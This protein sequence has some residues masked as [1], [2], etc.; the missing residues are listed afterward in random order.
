MFAALF[1]LG[2]VQAET[3]RVVAVSIL[4]S[5]FLSGGLDYLRCVICFKLGCPWFLLNIK[6][7]S[8]RSWS[9]SIRKS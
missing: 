1:T 4:V 7:F 2:M 9:L 8:P 3:A 6:L 5:S